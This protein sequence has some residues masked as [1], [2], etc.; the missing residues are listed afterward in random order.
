MSGDHRGVERGERSITRRSPEF[1]LGVGGLIGGPRNGSR[2]RR[3]P[4]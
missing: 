1:H 4:T 2:G 3:N